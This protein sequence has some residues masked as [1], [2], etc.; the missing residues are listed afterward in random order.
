MTDE[1][2]AQPRAIT[3]DPFPCPV[4]G[5]PRPWEAWFSKYGKGCRHPGP[6]NRRITGGHDDLIQ[7]EDGIR[8]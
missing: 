6:G 4:C 3:P 8:V 7:G 5:Q 2:T 1:P